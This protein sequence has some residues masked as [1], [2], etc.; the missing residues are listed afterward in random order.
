MNC[1]RLTS[2][3]PRWYDD[4]SKQNASEAEQKEGSVSP[5][6][7]CLPLNHTELLKGYFYRLCHSVCSEA[8]L[9]TDALERHDTDPPAIEADVLMD[10]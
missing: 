8:L 1:C 7:P 3:R 9:L 5:Y 10:L 4:F 2:D 6:V